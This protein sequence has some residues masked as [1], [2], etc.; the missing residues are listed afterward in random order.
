M[1]KAN[2]VQSA[3]E[4]RVRKIIVYKILEAKISFVLEKFPRHKECKR[5]AIL[6]WEHMNMCFTLAF[7]HLP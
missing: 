4:F 7:M 1:K 5:W 2:G 3:G 6:K